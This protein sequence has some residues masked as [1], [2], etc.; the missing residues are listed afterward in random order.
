MEESTWTEEHAFE[1]GFCVCGYEEGVCLHA[2]TEPIIV[3]IPSEE[4]YECIDEETH[5]A[6]GIS[7]ASEKCLICGEH[8]DVM[9]DLNEN[10]EWTEEHAFEEGF[11]VCGYEEGVC[12]HKNIKTDAVRIPNEALYAYIDA[13]THKAGGTSYTSR[14]C[15][16]CG[17][18]LEAAD[19]NE[20]AEWTEGHT[21]VI[22]AAVDATCTE[23]GLTEG[24]H[25]SACNEVLAAQ[26][27]IPALGHVIQFKQ[28][29][30]EAKIGG[31]AISVS[32]EFTC[33]HDADVKFVLPEALKAGKQTGNAISTQAAAQQVLPQAL[34]DIRAEA[35]ADL[36]L[37]R[38]SWAKMSPASAKRHLPTARTWF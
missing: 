38:L 10:A 30:Y 4:R 31:K 18:A 20:N 27:S 35:F 3:R 21:I 2:S 12:L 24:K 17:E 8:L 9:S 25:C 33:G 19:M 26:E 37:K 34:T 5:K 28:G 36:A 11:C 14:E 7:Y 29:V 15:L 16:D 32:V 23:P 22:D 6:G 13:D 1:E